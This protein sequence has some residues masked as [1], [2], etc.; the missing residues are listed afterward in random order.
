MDY[1]N[2]SNTTIMKINHLLLTWAAMPS[3]AL[4]Q[5]PITPPVVVDQEVAEST[6]LEVT[7]ADANATLD[8]PEVVQARLRL[9][10]AQRD[11][12]TALARQRLSRTPVDIVPT[13]DDVI[14]TT[15]TT[16]KVE[17]PGEPTRIYNTEK[18]V[19]LVQ[20]KELPYFTLPVLFVEGTA[21]LLDERSRF[22]VEDIAIAIRGV[23]ANDPTAVFDVEGHTSTDGSDEMNLQL[24]AD[25][26]RKIYQD[27][28][29]VYKLPTTALAAHGYGE[30][31]AKYPDGTEEQMVADRRVL[32]VRVK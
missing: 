17:V 8:S 31:F 27:L 5:N 19:V 28:I 26:A 24:S 13:G 11:L 12:D 29:D 14:E 22:A 3:I 23:L 7:P 1:G 21:E 9:K 20:G 4:A 10:Q 25:R 32:V 18:N 2:T 30:D 15:T 16:T 6:T